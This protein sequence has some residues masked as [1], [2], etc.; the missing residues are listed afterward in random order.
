MS[1]L[2]LDELNFQRLVFRTKLL[3]REDPDD[4]I[5]KLKA[6]IKSIEALFSR[7]QD[8]RHVDCVVVCSLYYHLLI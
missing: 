8:N 4:N 1:S 5:W 3:C 6:A 2:S 7:L